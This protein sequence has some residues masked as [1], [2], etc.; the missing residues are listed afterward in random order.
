MSDEPDRPRPVARPA[1][2]RAAPPRGRP[3]R[4]AASGR[5]PWL[6]LAVAA[7]AGAAVAAAAVLVLRP[8]PAP[9][10]V[11]PAAPA[12][13]VA[14][15]PPP[16]TPPPAPTAVV[17]RSRG[18]TDWIFFFKTGDRLVRMG[19]DTPL[20]LI[21]RTEKT[22]TFPDGTIG[23]AYLLQIPE[24]GQMFVDADQLERGARLE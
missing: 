7:A 10:V 23:P 13:V 2:R 6:G 11:E 8:A 22:H 12:A 14:P 17:S 15:V 16:E 5:R 24:G 18:R 4:P 21:I 9:P 1:E 3:S 19:E 20:G